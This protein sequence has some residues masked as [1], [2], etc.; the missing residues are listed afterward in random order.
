[1]KRKGKKI[2]LL[3][4]QSASTFSNSSFFPIFFLSIQDKLLRAEQKGE[5]ISM[6][7]SL[8]IL[9]FQML[10]LLKIST[11]DCVKMIS[12]FFSFSYF[13]S[14]LVQAPIC[15]QNNKFCLAFSFPY[16]YP[17]M[18]NNFAL[19]STWANLLCKL[20]SLFRLIW[21]NNI[22]IKKIQREE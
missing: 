19:I 6:K 10:L 1:M 5:K 14:H 8:G 17:K 12:I 22:I 15:E 20:K 7:N 11:F 21:K 4:K 2:K 16:S 18:N 3:L 13:L 9:Y